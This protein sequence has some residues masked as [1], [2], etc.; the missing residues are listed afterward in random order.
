MCQ[1]NIKQRY[2][3]RGRRKFLYTSENS[4]L[5]FWQVFLLMKLSEGCG[6]NFLLPC[7]TQSVFSVYSSSK[8]DGIVMQHYW[9]LAETIDKFIRFS[10]SKIRFKQRFRAGWKLFQISILRI[11][12]RWIVNNDKGRE[13]KS[14]KRESN[15]DKMSLAE[16]IFYRKFSEVHS[17]ADSVKGFSRIRVIYVTDFERGLKSPY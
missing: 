16:S 1:T 8:A 3:N 12:S 5:K 17:G 4:L 9:S 14:K 10:Y 11:F 15:R 7:F 6:K 13:R 2:R